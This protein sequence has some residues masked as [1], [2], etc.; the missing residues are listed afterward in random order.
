[1]C[2]ELTVAVGEE[3]ELESAVARAKANKLAELR[4]S[5]E[6]REVEFDILQIVTGVPRGEECDEST[7]VPDSHTNK[8]ERYDSFSESADPI[9]RVEEE[10][11]PSGV[12]NPAPSEPEYIYT[13]ITPELIAEGYYHVQGDTVHVV[14]MRGLPLT[15]EALRGREPAVVARL[16][17]RRD[18]ETDFW[19]PLPSNPN[20]GVA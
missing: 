15:S 4:S 12:T 17:L 2:I 5:G 8:W 11:V 7:S 13:Q 10:P 1:V 16:L 14:N 19:G 9:G 20:F 18:R 6:T 3:D